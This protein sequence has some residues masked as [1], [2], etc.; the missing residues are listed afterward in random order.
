MNNYYF[1]QDIAINVYENDKSI[2]KIISDSINMENEVLESYKDF[3]NNKHLIQDEYL[4]DFE[5]ELEKKKMFLLFRMQSREK[6]ISSL[7]KLIDYLKLV[8]D[9]NKELEINEIYKKI[10]YL[11]EKDIP[12]KL[13]IDNV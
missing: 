11:K 5:K 8:H 2:K 7:Y 4:T 3:I 10:D 12:I 13:F 1:P 9:K 6:Q